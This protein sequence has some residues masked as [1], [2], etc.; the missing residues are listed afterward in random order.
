MTRHLSRAWF[1]VPAAAVAL[2]GVLLHAQAPSP[3]LPVPGPAD[4]VAP[5]SLSAPFFDDST[6][7]S[8]TLNINSRDWQSL[9]DHFQ[10]NTYYPC[11][12]RWNGNVV[13]NVGIRSRG[14]GSRSGAKPGLRVDFDRYTSSQ[15]FLGLKSFILRN[16]TQDASNMHER[17]SML[18][19]R[20]LGV[21]TPR[22]AFTKLFINSTYAG[23]YT[24]VESVDKAFLRAAFNEDEG[25]LYKYDYNVDDSAYFFEDRGADPAAYVPHPFKPETHESDPRPEPIV[26][27]VRIV[28]NDSEAAFP[29]TVAPYVDWD[30]FTR[31]IAIENVLADQDGFNGNYGIN[32]FY[33]YR[34]ADR[35]LFMWIPWDKSEAFKDGPF[36]PIFHN[37]LD[38]VTQ[39]RNRLS[40]RAMSIPAVLNMY[41]ARLL[42]AAKSLRELD[43]ANPDDKRGWMEREIEREYAQ[44]HDLVYQDVQKPYSNE[45]FEAEV[46]RLRT[47][48]RERSPFVEK[49]VED[50]RLRR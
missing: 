21:K 28:N 7:Q 37:F 39:R 36:L 16:Q 32:N 34:L 25:Y 4:P 44:I 30:N 20:R 46:E 12:F 19:F 43:E 5:V 42:D 45:E 24:I 38:G 6:V 15:T 47:F 40:Q 8:I 23:L 14:T 11:D 27:F 50:F 48:A 29:T 18:L 2:C 35:N 13:R 10:D 26:E 41:L 17:I 31:H 49:A 1:P 9:K 22:E 3:P 33:W